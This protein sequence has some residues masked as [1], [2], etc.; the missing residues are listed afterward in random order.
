VIGVYG[1]HVRNRSSEH[2]GRRSRDFEGE[3]KPR[4]MREAMGIEIR[5]TMSEMSQAVPPAY[6]RFIGERLMRHLRDYE[7][8]G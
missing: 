1:A 8:I 3:D 7:L 6:T 5:Q 2:G 4:L